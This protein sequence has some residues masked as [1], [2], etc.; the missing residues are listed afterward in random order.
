MRGSHKLRLKFIKV[1]VD[2]GLVGFTK[3][4]KIHVA[5]YYTSRLKKL[6]C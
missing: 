3:A 1:L 2:A 6:L 4:I 5:A